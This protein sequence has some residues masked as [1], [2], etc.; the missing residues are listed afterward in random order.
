MYTKLINLYAAD[1]RKERDMCA[2]AA[3]RHAT[4]TK[5]IAAAATCDDDD[6]TNY[7][8]GG[9]GGGGSGGGENGNV[10]QAGSQITSEA[11]RTRGTRKPLAR[12][13]TFV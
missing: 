1:G 7:L 9:G 2:A 13:F 11:M 3:P 4:A 6:Q 5:Q 10:R 12:L 8:C